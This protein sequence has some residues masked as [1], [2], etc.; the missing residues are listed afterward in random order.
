MADVVLVVAPYAGIRIP[1]MALGILKSGLKNAGIETAVRYSNIQFAEEIGFDTYVFFESYSYEDLLG[2]WTFSRKAFP[3]FISNDTSFLENARTIVQETFNESQLKIL[4][5]GKRFD[6]FF[7]EIREKTSAHVDSEATVILEHNPRIVG[8]S[9]TFQNHCFS[10]AL[11][12]RIREL[13]PDVVTMLGGANCESTMGVVT[14]NNFVWVDYVVSGEADL[15][16]PPLCRDILKNGRYIDINKIPAG[17]LG[18]VHRANTNNEDV[19]STGHCILQDLNDSPIPDFDEYFTAIASSPLRW[20][21]YP[22]VIIETSRGCWWGQK[23][24]CVFCGFN[25]QSAKYRSKA[26]QRVIRELEHLSKKYHL[27]NFLAIDNILD[28]RYLHSLFPV[29]K[30][31]G[32]PYKLGYETKANL[33]RKQVNIMA[34]GGITCIQPGIESLH[35]AA[36]LR[37]NKGNKVWNNIELLKWTLEF[38]M[39]NNWVLL[40][41]LPD[42]DDRW[43]EEI[44]GMGPLLFHLQAP[45]LFHRIYFTRF[46]VY[47]KVPEKYDLKLQAFPSYRYV[48]P[49]SEEELQDFA[50]LFER[51]D[52]PHKQPVIGTGTGMK[53]L[54]KVLFEWAEMWWAFKNNQTER[55]CV[56]RMEEKGGTIEIQDTRPCSVER[57][58]SITGIAAEIYKICDT[59]VTLPQLMS[60]VHALTGSNISEKNVLSIL[61]R[62]EQCKLLLK[63]E[64]RYLSLAVRV[65]DYMFPWERFREKI[66]QKRTLN[67]F[68]EEAVLP[69]D[70]SLKVLFGR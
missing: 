13:A 19:T 22:M 68:D 27:Y 57:H 61:D 54:E 41:G 17:V 36:L 48:Y 16:L 15:I 42:D 56:V 45:N 23:N 9:S 38:G 24:Q 31:A 44:A 8:C 37:L 55:P 5:N 28:M 34:D 25:G 12:R 18:P 53:Q 30:D 66:K 35:N 29:L 1:S 39:V 64:D 50:Y 26:P 63:L 60:R 14:F 7:I 49:L 33:S 43:Y 21:I 32:A 51:V 62:F 65:S 6:D 4:L 20:Y 67:N 69:G 52:S 10:L 11:L 47:H 59:A 70:E 58:H 46:S 3:A 40:Y 2:E